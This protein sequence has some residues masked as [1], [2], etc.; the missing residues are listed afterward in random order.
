MK[1]IIGIIAVDIILSAALVL[2]YKEL[3]RQRFE[4]FKSLFRKNKIRRS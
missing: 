4:Y 3:Y 1:I 2:T